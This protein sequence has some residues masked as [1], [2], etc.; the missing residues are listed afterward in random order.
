MSSISKKI[1]AIT[2]IAIGA[3]LFIVFLKNIKGA[4]NNGWV[5]HE[6]GSLTFGASDELTLLESQGLT[7][8]EHVELFSDNNEDHVTYC[9]IAKIQGD[10]ASIVNAYTQALEALLSRHHVDPANVKMD[11]ITV[12]AN[13]MSTIFSYDIKKKQAL[14]YGFLKQQGNKIE[15][16]WLIP[17]S[18]RFPEDYM[19]KFKEGINVQPVP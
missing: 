15:S 2:I 4:L 7:G 1:L 11:D 6:I 3:I 16:L 8:L 13:E 10:S 9:L 5:Q 18:K 19:I 12:D 14:G 17:V